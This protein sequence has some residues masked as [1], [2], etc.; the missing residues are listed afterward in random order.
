IGTALGHGLAKLHQTIG[1]SFGLEYDNFVGLLP[2]T[3]KPASSWIAFYRD[4]RIRP[5]LDI[6]NKKGR[7]TAERR[8]YA[9]RMLDRLNHWIDDDAVKPSLIHGDLWAGNWISTV[10][11]PALIDPAVYYGDREMD[12]AMASLFGGFP[13][14]F[15]RSY[16][17]MY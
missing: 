14:S 11:G 4:H 17:D 16:H 9:E 6:A 1:E 15:F 13:P 12:L 3:N 10:D 8:R 2:Q 5:Q 7:L